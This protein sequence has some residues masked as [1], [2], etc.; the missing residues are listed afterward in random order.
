MLSMEGSGRLRTERADSA[1]QSCIRQA[2]EGRR[3]VAHP[4]YGNTGSSAQ[5]VV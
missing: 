1:N 2:A 4:G 5:G 3:K